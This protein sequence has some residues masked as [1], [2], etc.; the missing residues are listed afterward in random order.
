MHGHFDKD[1]LIAGLGNIN[2]L[3]GKN[4]GVSLGGPQ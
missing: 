2:S 4:G 3:A 1:N